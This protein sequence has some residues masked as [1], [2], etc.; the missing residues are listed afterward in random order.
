MNTI[1][2]DSIHSLI[3]LENC[4][5]QL[6]RNLAQKCMSI[7]KK[8]QLLNGGR[9]SFQIKFFQSRPELV[10]LWL[11]KQFFAGDPATLSPRANR[12]LLK[13]DDTMTALVLRPN[14]EFNMCQRSTMDNPLEHAVNL[15]IYMGLPPTRLRGVPGDKE[16]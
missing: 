13:R 12:L 16:N 8:L 3:F 4:N 6:A 10:K 7:L 15:W 9:R 2:R 11:K 1:S 14:K 5:F